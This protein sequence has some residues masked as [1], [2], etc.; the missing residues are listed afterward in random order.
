MLSIKSFVFNPAQENTYI[1]YS[2]A[3]NAII[4]DPGCYFGS[5]QRSVKLFLEEKQL[6]LVKLIN[7]HCHL[8]HIFGNKWINTTYQLEPHLHPEEEKIIA[9]A[10]QSALKWGLTIDQYDGALHFFNEGDTISL[11]EHELSIIHL[12]GHSPG[13]V[14]FYHAKDGFIISGDVLFKQSIGR[15]DLPFGDFDTLIDSIKSKLFL[16]PND[17]I[18][19]NGHGSSTTIGYEKKANPFLVG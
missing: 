15:T 17:T 16:L 7:T 18:V 3:G 4:I 14:G 13:S 11:D 9:W 8:D 2:D 19:Y 12:P 1:I 5:E 6:K 10:P